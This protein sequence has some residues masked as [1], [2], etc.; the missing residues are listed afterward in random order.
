MASYFRI[1][2]D[3]NEFDIPTSPL[4]AELTV[5]I[6]ESHWLDDPAFATF[7]HPQFYGSPI[8]LE[9]DPDPEFLGFW[10]EF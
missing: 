6:V 2:L 4:R 9:T 10:I 1:R 3:D 8:I 5:P 7:L